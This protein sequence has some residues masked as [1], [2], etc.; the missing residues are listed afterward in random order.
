MLAKV[1][2]KWLNHPVD[3]SLNG[4]EQM[5]SRETATTA[6]ETKAACFSPFK[7]F[8]EYMS[9]FREGRDPN[10][11]SVVPTQ[12]VEW[13]VVRITDRA[14]IFR[15]SGFETARIESVETAIQYG[16]PDAIVRQ[17]NE[18]ENAITGLAANSETKIQEQYR[19]D[20]RKQSD[21]AGVLNLIF[22]RS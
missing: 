7:N 14:V 1:K 22:G 11:T 3:S 15:K 12:G 20:A 8:T 4:S 13:S 10:N 19:A 21:N 2:I 16:A 6:I 18:L 5:V 9:Q 17:F